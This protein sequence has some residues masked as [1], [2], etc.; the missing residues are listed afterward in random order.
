MLE[1]LS[2]VHNQ[3]QPPALLIAQTAD[4]LEAQ[5]GC[6]LSTIAGLWADS[7]GKLGPRRSF[8]DSLSL[9]LD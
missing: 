2:K 5:T 6:D 3:G 9:K 4:M 8:P 7:V 1:S